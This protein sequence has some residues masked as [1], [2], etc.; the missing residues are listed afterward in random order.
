LLAS[1]LFQK[2]NSI[3]KGWGSSEGATSFTPPMLAAATG[4]VKSRAI[5]IHL[6]KSPS[7]KISHNPIF[8]LSRDAATS[9]VSA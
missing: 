1:G 2:D 8:N 4:V 5:K 3:A 9:M 6:Q 7:R